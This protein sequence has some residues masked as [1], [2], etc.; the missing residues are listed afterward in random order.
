MRKK[1][2]YIDRWKNDYDFRTFIN[3]FGAVLVTAIF[4]LYN[5]YLGI[6]HKSAW[7]GG[8]C[9]YYLLLILIRGIVIVSERSNARKKQPETASLERKRVFLLA[10][11][12][13]FLLNI[14]LVAPFALMVKQ[15]R[16]VS[17]TLIPAIAMAAYTVY[18]VVIRS[19]NLKKNR[20]ENLL[21][22]FLRM[23][24]FIDALVSIAALQNTLIM[25]NAGDKLK[26]L[27]LTA[28][29]SGLIWA[30]IV[31]LSIMNLKQAVIR[32]V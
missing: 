22:R 1:N 13:L 11:V 12:L 31:M 10:S 6:S 32:K 3:T 16:P 17:M 8:I 18:K 7:H 14:S 29:T 19:L 23:I 25:V 5:G 28:V 21:V 9:I 2:S 27:P 26:M 20:S 4:A 15:E 24:N 30:A